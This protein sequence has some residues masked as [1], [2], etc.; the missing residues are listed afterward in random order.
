[1]EKG[2]FVHE[3]GA[4]AHEKGAFGAWKS[5]IMHFEHWLGAKGSAERMHVRF[6]AVQQACFKQGLE[7]MDRPNRRIFL[8]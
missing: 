7:P 8:F 1:M 5:H 2:T 3:K 4:F 6:M